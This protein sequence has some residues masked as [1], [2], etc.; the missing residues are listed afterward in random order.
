[1][2]TVFIGQPSAALVVEVVE[3]AY[4]TVRLELGTLRAEA[5]VFRHYA[6][7][8]DD[9]AEFFEWLE[10]DWRG[11]DGVRTWSSLEGD[12]RLQA[13]NRGQVGVLVE[14][15]CPAGLPEWSVKTQLSIEPGEQLS[16][17]TAQIRGLAEFAGQRD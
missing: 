7:G 5:R 9:L 16:L 6:S 3:P 13:S 15:E 2:T 8:F 10:R 4:L 11:W 12:L 17:I 14:L 1:M